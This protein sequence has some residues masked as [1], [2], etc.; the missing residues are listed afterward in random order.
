MARSSMHRKNKSK[1]ANFDPMAD[2]K[3]FELEEKMAEKISSMVKERWAEEKRR[4][5]R[6]TETL[7][8]ERGKRE[9][10]KAKTVT[11]PIEDRG[12]EEERCRP[13]RIES[14]QPANLPL[15]ESAILGRGDAVASVLV[16]DM[17]GI[18]TSRTHNP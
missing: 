8:E 17:L 14:G 11:S 5:R 10:Q 6:R 9:K 12:T 1:A 4:P 13:R 2:V 3:A 16:D 18:R 7:E 15:S